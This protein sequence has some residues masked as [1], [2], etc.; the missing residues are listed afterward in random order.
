MHELAVN[1]PP[2]RLLER[3]AKAARLGADNDDGAFQ[4]NGRI[5]GGRTFI[6]QQCELPDLSRCPFP[7]ADTNHVA[8]SG[9]STFVPE[10]PCER[11][12][13]IFTDTS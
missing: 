1:L 13:N 2:N 8:Q 3:L 12:R 10:L 5:R 9:K 4:Q 7:A 6:G 11:I